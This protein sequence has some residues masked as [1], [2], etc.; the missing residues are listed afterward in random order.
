MW[1]DLHEPTCQSG[2]KLT[3]KCCQLPTINITVPGTRCWPPKGLPS[4]RKR[5]SMRPSAVSWRNSS[6]KRWTRCGL[7][8]YN[9]IVGMIETI[10]RKQWVRTV[11][12]FDQLLAID[13]HRLF[14][15]VSTVSDI[16]GHAWAWRSVLGIPKP[17]CSWAKRCRLF[18]TDSKGRS[19]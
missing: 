19:L 9:Q 7:M 10:L 3:N 13:L 15:C 11:G 14:F 8:V 2:N 18:Q 6:N 5:P 12:R 16:S 4:A 17:L 1:C